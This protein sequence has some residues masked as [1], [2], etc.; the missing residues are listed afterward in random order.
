MGNE[1][2]INENSKKS[3]ENGGLNRVENPY[4]TQARTVLTR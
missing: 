2:T 4:N 1:N 3:N